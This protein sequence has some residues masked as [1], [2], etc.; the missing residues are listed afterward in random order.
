MF[1]QI[2]II[3]RLLCLGAQPSDRLSQEWKAE[4][5]HDYEHEQDLKAGLY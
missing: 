3:I 2:I 1:K 4:Q 5:L